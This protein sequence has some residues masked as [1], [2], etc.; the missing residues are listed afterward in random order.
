M[1]DSEEVLMYLFASVACFNSEGTFDILIKR[2]NLFKVNKEWNDLFSSPKIFYQLS[3]F[4]NSVERRKLD[5]IALRIALDREFFFMIDCI[6]DRSVMT[7]EIVQILLTE[8]Q[9]K[10]LVQQISKPKRP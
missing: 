8:N 5:Q 2:N 1:Y 7:K 6:L 9:K 4:Q 3:S 10:L